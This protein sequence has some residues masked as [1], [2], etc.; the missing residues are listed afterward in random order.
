ML[1]YFDPAGW[2]NVLTQHA[3]LFYL[4]QLLFKSYYIA[5]LK[6]ENA[7]NLKSL[8]EL[9]ETTA[10]IKQYSIVYNITYIY[11]RLTS[12]LERNLTFKSSILN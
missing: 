9:L 8:I 2:D 4:S 10:I 1:G 3:G 5:A 6:W 12:I 7:G 11:T